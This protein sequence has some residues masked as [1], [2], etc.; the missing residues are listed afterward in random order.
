MK[1]IEPHRITSVSKT[2]RHVRAMPVTGEEGGFEPE[3]KGVHLTNPNANAITLKG[4]N[5]IGWTQ[6][7]GGK[8]TLGS[9]N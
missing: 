4:P 1:N 5:A 8:D 6:N 7:A 9:Q 3:A 2:F